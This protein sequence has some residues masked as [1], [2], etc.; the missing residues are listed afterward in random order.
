MLESLAELSNILGAVNE[1][2]KWFPI[3]NSKYI[4]IAAESVTWWCVVKNILEN[5]SE[6]IGKYMQ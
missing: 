4:S 3:K 1:N 6:I 5:F 2:F